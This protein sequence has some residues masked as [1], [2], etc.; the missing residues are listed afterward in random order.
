MPIAESKILADPNASAADKWRAGSMAVAKTANLVGLGAG[1]VGKNPTLVG[2]TGKLHLA[3][4]PGSAGQPGHNIVGVTTKSGTTW[5][6]RVIDTQAGP[7]KQLGEVPLKAPGEVQM[8]APGAKYQ[9]AEVKV[10]LARAESALAAAKAQLG[11]G[12]FNIATSNCTTFA[13]E[14]LNA[15]GVTTP[16]V[17]PS[18]A[19]GVFK[20][21]PFASQAVTGVGTTSA[22]TQA[23]GK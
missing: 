22:A 20:N 7:A 11:P 13:R 23:V 17:M 12:P 18:M 4:K 5:F 8:T 16:A 2:E 21:V 19:M 9:H 14:I 6:D 1:I 3:Y 15:G 10:P